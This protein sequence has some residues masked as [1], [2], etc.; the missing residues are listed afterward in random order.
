M[1]H[2]GI[3]NVTADVVRKAGQFLLTQSVNVKSHKSRNDLLTENDLVIENFII[4]GIKKE[5]PEIN[6]LSEE[7]NP[8]NDLKGTTVVID[9]IDGTCNFAQG[10]ALY[11][12]QCA[13]FDEDTLCGAVMY[14]PAEDILYT[15]EA[16]KGVYRNGEKLFSDTKKQPSD[17]F[18]IISDYYDNIDID[19]DLQFDLVKKLQPHF[20]KTRH[21]GAACVDFRMLIE[22][23]ALAYI[24]YYHK[25]W[26]ISPGLLFAKEAGFAYSAVD[27]DKY[28]FNRPG[29]IVAANSDIL[30]I[31]KTNANDLI[32]RN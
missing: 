11:G 20:L 2:K 13:I 21:F 6:I 14:F 17:G 32:K 22:G 31:I 28:R 25:I 24:T 5:Y 8:S 18:L 3:L 16:G 29:L 9:P 27:S 4:D 1:E 7:Y 19:F 12:I 15:A 10:L 26:D 30:D 23:H